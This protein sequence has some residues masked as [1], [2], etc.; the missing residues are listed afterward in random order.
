MRSGR[1]FALTAASLG[2]LAACHLI[3][4]TDDL[5][6]VPVVEST[7]YADGGTYSMRNGLVALEF[8]SDAGNALSSVAIQRGSNLNVLY[9]G[10]DTEERLAGISYWAHDY[11]WRANTT[12]TVLE[13]HPLSQIQLDWTTETAAGRSVYTLHPDGRLHRRELVQVT[14]SFGTPD[15]GDADG[16][17]LVDAGESDTGGLWAPDF[18]LAY[19]AIDTNRFDHV[20]ET[21][22]GTTQEQTAVSDLYYDGDDSQVGYLCASN[23]AT[24]DVVAWAHVMP[25][26]GIYAGARIYPRSGTYLFATDWVRDNSVAASAYMG[27][28]LTLFTAADGCEAVRSE[29]EAFLAP[30]SLGITGGTKETWSSGDDNQDGYDEGGGFYVV[31][32]ASQDVAL[33]L[34]LEGTKSLASASFRLLDVGSVD[35]LAVTLDGTTLRRGEG[36][37]IANRQAD[38]SE[39]W[40]FLAREWYEGTALTITRK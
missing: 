35:G 29:V 27:S 26:G 15:A 22:N 2:T 40:L 19:V 16:G 7:A 4:S 23:A 13:T 17:V 28:F 1:L 36:Y 12:I 38:A 33:T 6:S 21:H 30:P 9:T 24:R 18:L 25:P 39:A 14:Q 37:L 20:F 10:E 8:G 34:E 32:S 11:S 5:T 3:V 31:K